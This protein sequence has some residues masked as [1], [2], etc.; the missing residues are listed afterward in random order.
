MKAMLQRQLLLVQYCTFCHGLFDDL[1]AGCQGIQSLK[2]ELP[3]CQNIKHPE[4]GATDQRGAALV[5]ES[6]STTAIGLMAT[7]NSG[8]P[9]YRDLDEECPIT[10]LHG[11][12]SALSAHYLPPLEASVNRTPQ[13]RPAEHLSS[14]FNSH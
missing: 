11:M 13:L 6:S 7:A 3:T 10:L 8:I 1:C 2:N 9:G 14:P 12:T 4:L 5:T